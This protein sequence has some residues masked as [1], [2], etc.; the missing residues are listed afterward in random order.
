[1]TGQE[2]GLASFYHS[3]FHGR[4]TSS[5]ML[6]DKNEFT[7]AHRT[8]PNGTYLRVTNLSNMQSVV[9]LVNDRGPHRRTRM[10][11]LS[12]AAAKQLDFI[13]KGITRV[14]VEVVPGPFYS[15]YLEA[16]HPTPPYLLF[17]RILPFPETIGTTVHMVSN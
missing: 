11:D 9:V 3:R 6:Y 14:R 1:M 12:E 17:D 13:P 7:A 5:G 16:L 15:H 2:E 8:Y 4:K 10:I